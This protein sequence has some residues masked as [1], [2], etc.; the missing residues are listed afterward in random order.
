[1]ILTHNHGDH[2]GSAA[3]VL[4]RAPDATGYAGAEDIAG[5]TVPRA[6]TPVQD[7][8]DVFDLQVVTAPGHT[9]GS[10]AVLDPAAGGILVVGDAIGTSGGSRRSRAPSSPRTW[11][12]RRRSIVKLGGLT[13]ETLLLGHGEPIEGGRRR[14]S[15][16]LARA[17]S[18]SSRPRYP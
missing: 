13:F 1:M 14:S 18:R 11:T 9:P 6:L 4:D 5:I 7:G 17:G 12:R 10:I 15:R 2:P 8:D 16:S 3:D